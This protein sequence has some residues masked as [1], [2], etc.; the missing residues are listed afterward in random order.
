MVRCG[1]DQQVRFAPREKKLE[2]VNRAERLLGEI[3]PRKTYSYEFLCF[4]ITDFR[5][6]SLGR[7]R[8]YTRRQEISGVDGEPL[9]LVYKIGGGSGDG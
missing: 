1:L 2:Q 8:G 9:K 7:K 4:R 3:D 6:E 5:P